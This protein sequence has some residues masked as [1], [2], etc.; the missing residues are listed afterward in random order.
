MEYA[1]MASTGSSKSTEKVRQSARTHFD[2]FCAS[3]H[4]PPWKELSEDQ[5]CDVT[6]FREFSTYL[7]EHAL[8]ARTK[9]LLMAGSAV[10]YLGVIKELAILRFPE[11]EMWHLHELDKWY[12]S[13][14]LAIETKV[15][16]RRMK[17]GQS[18]SDGS[19]P[20]GRALLSKICHA[21]MLIGD[22]ESMKRRFAIVTTFLAVG[23]A[24][25]VAC[26]SWNS[27]SWD[28]DLQNLIM[29]WKEMKT[30]DTDKMNFFSDATSKL[31][32]FYHALSCYLILG[33]GNSTLT[34]SSDANWII[35]D[36]ARNQETAASVM[37]KYVRSALE[38][39][40]DA[41]LSSNA[42]DYEG[43]SLR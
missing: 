15:N 19:N 22:S 10:Q 26:S 43:T 37:T 2:F 24:G 30:G 23:R 34:A 40:E 13:L 12:P 32:D 33:G 1:P 35:P 4:L 20:I 5:F 41:F 9:M 16:R 25:E 11:N 38:S 36:L 14:R 3:K 39:S 7:A 42:K 18:T 6:L 28:Y 31:M 17:A 8:V 27:V 21:L 29:D